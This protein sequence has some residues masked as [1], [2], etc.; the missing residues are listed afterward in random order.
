MALKL[1]F[2]LIATFF[3]TCICAAQQKDARLLP[4]KEQQLKQLVQRTPIVSS[5]HLILLSRARSSRL[6]G[7]AYEQYTLLWK[8]RSKNAHTNLWRGISAPMYWRHSKSATPQKRA[9]RSEDIF[10]VA[11]ACL[12]KAVE[13]Q[14]NSATANM[15]YGFFLWQYG[16]RVDEGLALL[17]KA[18]LLAPRD[19]RAHTFLGLV[20]SNPTGNA[21]NLQ[22]AEKALKTAIRLDASY[23]FP[24][25]LLASIYRRQGRH[26]EAQREMQA[27]RSLLPQG[28]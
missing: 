18:A 16:N 11:R 21:Y 27:Y 22:K 10:I 23:A 8:N 17:R 13:L 9:S 28:G 15:E 6:T 2:A 19:P 4:I 5:E 24:H 14:P 3:T 7:F 25:E 12:A 26:Q 1:Y 20:Y